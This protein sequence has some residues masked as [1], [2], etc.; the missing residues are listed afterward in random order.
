MLL[1]GKGGIDM[2]VIKDET[3]IAWIV[4]VSFRFFCGLI[5]IFG[6]IFYFIS[7]NTILETIIY[8][9]LLV[10][11]V[12]AWCSGK[13]LRVNSPI[14][15]WIKKAFQLRCLV[16]Y[17]C[18]TIYLVIDGFDVL[19]LTFSIV[20]IALS[21]ICFFIGMRLYDEKLMNKMIKENIKY[22]DGELDPEQSPPGNILLY[23]FRSPKSKLI[24]GVTGSVFKF[25]FL[26]II[27]PLSLLGGGAG[28]FTLEI[29]RFFLGDSTISP[30]AIGF[31]IVCL[32]ASMYLAF[33]LPALINFN[34]KWKTI[35]PMK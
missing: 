19:Y 8:A 35:Y 28:Y 17:S 14:S 25:V 31:F 22:I 9:P 34:R 15:F 29:F 3:Y 5:F 11:S 21:V 20:V 18:V 4:T 32:P 33:Q 16:F 24:T 7:D 26:F 30:H 6:T 2:K 13:Q 12:Y 1:A 27:F 23:S 10:F